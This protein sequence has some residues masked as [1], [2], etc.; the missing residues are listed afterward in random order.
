MPNVR[1]EKCWR[2]EYQLP[3]GRV[4]IKLPKELGQQPNEILAYNMC[5]PHIRILRE[6]ITGRVIKLPQALPLTTIPL[7]KFGLTVN[8]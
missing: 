6:W 7:D 2:P 5:S 8:P 1:C 4:F 3:I